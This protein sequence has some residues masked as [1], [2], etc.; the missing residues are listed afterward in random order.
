MTA[1]RANP[2]SAYSSMQAYSAGWADATARTT[3]WRR[4]GLA[5]LAGSLS[6]LGPWHLFFGRRYY[7]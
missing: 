7:S 1:A 6:V 4:A 2:K 5:F 3:G